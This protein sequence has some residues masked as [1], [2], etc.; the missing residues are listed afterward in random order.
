MT[1]EDIL[2]DPDNLQLN[3]RYARQRVKA[4]NLTAAVATLERML[5][6][7]PGLDRVRLF[8]ALVLF[9]LDSLQEAEEQLRTLQDRDLP[10]ELA[11]EVERYLARIARRQQR[12]RGRAQ[13]SVGARYDTNPAG[14]TDADTV[15]LL[16]VEVQ[17]AAQEEDDF[18]LIAAGDLGFEYDP[19]TAAGHM[20]FGRLSYYQDH[21]LDVEV[22]RLQALTG[23][24]GASLRGEVAT[25]TPEVFAS[26]VRLDYDGYAV[27]AGGRATASTAVTDRL[28]LSV[29]L[30]AQHEEFRDVDVNQTADQRDGARVR[31]AIAGSY[32]VAPNHRLS[33]GAALEE[34]SAAARFF[35]YNRRELSGRYVGALG[36]GQYVVANLTYQLDDYDAADPLVDPNTVREDEWWRSRLTYG[37]PIGTLAAWAGQTEAGP[38]DEV[39]LSLSLEYTERSSNLN[40][41]EFENFG[42]QVL[43]TRSFPF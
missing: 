37:V 17:S 19:G 13:I 22:Q 6:I 23:R 32:D 42:T 10:P 28:G 16:G 30:T 40:N 18:G 27:I 43:V 3:F 31:A 15:S 39:V 7:E 35:A 12:L 34:K 26:G 21:Q 11:E 38:L 5:L 1:R 24:A 36:R 9:R 25:L 8:Y 2:A 29:E 41:F 4:G 20:L 33:L 14:V